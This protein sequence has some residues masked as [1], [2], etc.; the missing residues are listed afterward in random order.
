MGCWDL[1]TTENTRSNSVKGPSSYLNPP[2]FLQPKCFSHQFF[3]RIYNDVLEVTHV[4]FIGVL[5]VSPV[6]TSSDPSPVP[7]LLNL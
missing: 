5:R 2:L 6:S 4:K 3:S 7:T 1:S